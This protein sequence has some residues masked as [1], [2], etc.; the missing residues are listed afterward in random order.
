MQVQSQSEGTYWNERYQRNSDCYNI[1][2]RY[3]IGVIVIDCVLLLIVRD[4]RSNNTIQLLL[5]PSTSQVTQRCVND[6][7]HNCVYNVHY[8]I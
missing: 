8:V 4:N 2:V 1:N 3:L 6:E 5:T 7:L